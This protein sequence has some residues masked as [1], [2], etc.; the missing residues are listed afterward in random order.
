MEIHQLVGDENIYIFGE[1]SDT[2]IRRY[3]EHSYVSAAY[4]EADER[5]KEA[6]DFLTGS[7]MT[8]VGDRACLERLQHELLSKDWFMTFPDFDAYVQTKEQ[9]YEDYE[10]RSAWAKK[11]LINISKAGYFSSDRTIRQYAEEIWKL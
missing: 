11:M 3:A 5:L 2:V 8:A 6:V 7:E 1:D 10:D 4:Y 9:M